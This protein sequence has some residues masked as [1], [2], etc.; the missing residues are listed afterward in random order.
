M[1]DR[2]RRNRSCHSDRDRRY[3]CP[4]L[5]P[6]PLYI[7]PPESPAMDRLHHDEPGTLLYHTNNVAV[8]REHGGGGYIEPVMIGDEPLA[9]RLSCH[10]LCCNRILNITQFNIL[11]RKIP[12]V[13]RH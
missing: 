2:S 4:P 1:T 3:L 6:C 5:F 8:C 10:L 13:E 12:L 9:K 11:L 7:K